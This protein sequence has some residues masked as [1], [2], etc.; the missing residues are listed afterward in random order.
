MILTL[1]PLA[2][3]NRGARSSITLCR[4]IV[5]S[6]LIS[7]ALAPAGIPPSA[8]TMTANTAGAVTFFIAFLAF[9]SL[10]DR[11]SRLMRSN[12]PVLAR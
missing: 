4:A 3:S 10:T 11:E 1:W 9:H 6:A 12:V 8:R 2:F 5:A 7:A